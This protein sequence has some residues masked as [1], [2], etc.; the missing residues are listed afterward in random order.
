MIQLALFHYRRIS[1]TAS[2]TAFAIFTLRP[3]LAFITEA[4]PFGAIG[5][6]IAATVDGTI[7]ACPT[8]IAFA[9]VIGFSL[10]GSVL[11]DVIAG[12]SAREPAVSNE[13]P[14]AVTTVRSVRIGAD[15]F[16]MAIVQ[17]QSAFVHVRTLRVSPS[18]V[19]NV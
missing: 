3:I 5:M 7:V 2:L 8:E 12:A 9:L 19:W 14:P 1:E 13:T 4:R 18:G 11:A 16:G 6:I 17:T 10:T 15:S